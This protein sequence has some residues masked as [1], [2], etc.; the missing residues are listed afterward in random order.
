M[1]PTPYCRNSASARAGSVPRVP[2]PEIEALI[3]NVRGRFVSIERHV[4][5]I[6]VKPDAIELHLHDT[7]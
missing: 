1:S 6:V 4:D 2:A 5:R 3:V 7:D